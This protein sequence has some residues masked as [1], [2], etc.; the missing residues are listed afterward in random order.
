MDAKEELP[1]PSPEEKK[2]CLLL[3]SEQFGKV[4]RNVAACFFTRDL[5]SS[6]ELH[7]LYVKAHGP[8]LKKK[9]NQYVLL[10]VQY[11]IVE[12]IVKPRKGKG[13]FYYRIV[14]ANVL[15]RLRFPAFVQR[16][17]QKFG[18][19]GEIIM[20]H[21]L[22]N[23][24]MRFDQSI[25]SL[26]ELAMA[27]QED[28]LL[29]SYDGLKAQ[30]TGVF[31]TMCKHKFMVRVFPIKLYQKEKEEEVVKKTKKRAKV[32]ETEPDDG[33][34]VKKRKRIVKKKENTAVP[35]ELMGM[36]E[37][38]KVVTKVKR[39]VKL[40]DDDSKSTIWRAGF[41]QMILDARHE[42]CIRFA[43]ESVNA[44]AGTIVKAILDESLP[45]ETCS[46]EVTSI[47]IG[48]ATVANVAGVAEALPVKGPAVTQLVSNYMD[49]MC[50]EKS[51]ILVHATY[52]GEF[53]VHMRNV[54]DSLKRK[55]LHSMLTEKFG[56]ESAR[57]VKVLIENRQMEEKRIGDLALLPGS[58][59][60]RRLMEMYAQRFVKLQEV[61]KKADYNPAFTIFCWSVDMDMVH[62]Q[63]KK[64]I[65]LSLCRLRLRRSFEME[66]G[67]GLI[68]RS[69]SLTE[70]AEIKQ[71]DSL[72]R[73]LDRLDQVSLHLVEMLSLYYF[74]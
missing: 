62:V 28:N 67:K 52:Q 7:A 40:K 50:K 15:L 9:L 19:L 39:I 42:V 66:N 32:V 18:I 60:R 16:C 58:E 5:V 25:D 74:F 41:D 70:E 48:P 57:I 34:T 53:M 12:T 69:E 17:Q 61:P 59:V 22:V 24:R 13:V 63:I 68:Q 73:S 11:N 35:V 56:V 64:Q 29:D 37:E 47:G 54:M 36:M 26:V 31:E 20:E 43:S 38:E 3:I 71:F 4:M 23:G 30:L 33:I 21:V 72:S 10:L 1:F 51:H 8:I 49:L 55:T 6:S 14:R 27:R 2:I 46:T 44:I 65:L 45:Q